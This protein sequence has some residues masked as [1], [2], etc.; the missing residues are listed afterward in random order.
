M[1][2]EPK[3][4]IKNKVLAVTCGDHQGIGPEILAR[5]LASF[6][7]SGP[8]LLLGCPEDFPA[9]DPVKENDLDILEDGRV[10]RLAPIS[11]AHPAAVSFDSFVDA[12]SLAQA[13]LIAG[14]VT[15]PVAKHRWLA[16]GVPYLGHS[17][18]L[19]R[20]CNYNLIMC[21]WSDDLKTALFTT[22]IPLQELWRHFQKSR[23]IDFIIR[24]DRELKKLFKRSFP[25]ICPGLNPHSGE[26][27]SM[28]LEER[29]IIIP[30]LKSLPEVITVTG[31]L[32]PDTAFLQA[33]KMRNAVALAWYHDQA[34][35]PFK[36]INFNRGAQLSLGLPF[37]RTS[38]DHGT[39]EE[40]SGQGRADPGSMLAA[41][42]LASDLLKGDAGSPGDVS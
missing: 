20:A 13:G 32:S 23:I 18:Y 21:F 3:I 30:A 33:A 35:L 28:G 10:Y 8:L 17:D 2:G 15:G 26:G 9:A 27:G 4:P 16:A 19:A 38:P 1:I 6:S 39:A 11:Q 31:P 37:I 25:L 41:L 36:M 24:T 22:H 40:I 12:V 42:R 34:L 5:A 7:H 29:D 14:L